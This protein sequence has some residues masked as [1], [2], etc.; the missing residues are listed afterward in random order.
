MS[1]SIITDTSANLPTAYTRE[2]GI[3]VVPFS[4]YI[5]GKA[6]SCM[7][8]EAF[9]GDAFLHSQINEMSSDLSAFSNS[10]LPVGI[11]IAKR[12]ISD[13]EI[14]FFASATR[15]LACSASLSR[16]VIPPPPGGCSLLSAFPRSVTPCP[17]LSAQQRGTRPLSY[18]PTF[19][20][21]IAPRQR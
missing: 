16:I 17:N 2:H 11:L 6:L 1:Y 5:D 18:C 21:Y 8:T 15:S 4:Y 10:K 12:H 14:F 7:D 13:E 3:T 9:D 19:R 20:L